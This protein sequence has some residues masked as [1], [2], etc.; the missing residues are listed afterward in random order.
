MVTLLQ[1]HPWLQVRLRNVFL[2]WSAIS[3]ETLEFWAVS[4]MKKK[5]E[6]MGVKDK[7]SH[8]YLAAL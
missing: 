2:G 7:V 6:Q 1:N 5:K 8:F 3:S 4:V